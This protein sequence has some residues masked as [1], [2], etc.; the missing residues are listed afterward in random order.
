MAKRFKDN[1]KSIKKVCVTSLA[2]ILIIVGIF[3]VF[4]YFYKKDNLSVENSTY[5]DEANNIDLEII[6]SEN[7]EENIIENQEEQK[8]SNEIENNVTENKVVENKVQEK[9]DINTVKEIKGYKV[10]GRIK[11]NKLNYEYIILDKTTTES[12]KL[13][14]TKFWGPEMN[15]VGN[16]SISGHNYQIDRSQLF[17][18]LDN[19]VEGDTFSLKDLKGRTVNYKIY[20][21]YKVLP[22]DTSPIDQ[23][24]DGK[25]EVTLITCTRNAKER[26]IFKAREY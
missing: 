21:K 1:K 11:I 18:K 20:K 6:E 13:G 14:L 22:S 24:E 8:E 4:Q 2:V 17:S 26:I 12:L 10:I 7:N 19:L 23:N 5:N 3:I 9:I 16:F 25:R 15:E